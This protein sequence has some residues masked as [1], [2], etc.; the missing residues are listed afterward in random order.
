[1]C[2]E[3]FANVDSSAKLAVLDRHEE[4]DLT[5]RG[6]ALGRREEREDQPREGADE[7]APVAAPVVVRV[8]QVGEVGGARIE[9]VAGLRAAHARL[10]V[11]VADERE[12]CLAVDPLDGQQRAHRRAPAA[13]ALQEHAAR[14]AAGHRAEQQQRAERAAV[15]EPELAQRDEADEQ[16]D[17]DHVAVFLQP[18]RRLERLRDPEHARR[19]VG[20]RQRADVAPQAR[21]DHEGHR[22]QRDHDLPH[23]EQARLRG[24]HEQ[25]GDDERREDAADADGA[26]RAQRQLRRDLR[27][28]GERDGGHQPVHPAVVSPPAR[29]RA[30]RI[31]PRSSRISRP[32]AASRAASA[33]NAS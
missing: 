8:M 5:E 29:S 3:T 13:L 19:L 27:G 18:L 25:P 15:V 14:E 7:E 4:R 6:D 26:P 16:R 23:H 1:M 22:Q 9:V 30:E 10:A 33:S 24:R 11:A 32:S 28:V 31:R 2:A 20:G 17:G 21:R 12:R